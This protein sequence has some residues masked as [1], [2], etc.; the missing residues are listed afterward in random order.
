MKESQI[1]LK[2]LVTEID[3]SAIIRNRWC[4]RQANVAQSVER[5]TRNAQVWG[6]S[7][8]IGSIIGA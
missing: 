8:H 1:F 6:P 2:N 3:L 5:R 7:P 4:T